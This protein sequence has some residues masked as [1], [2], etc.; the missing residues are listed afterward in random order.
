L[1][2]SAAVAFHHVIHIAASSARRHQLK[3]IA[4]SYTVV[5]GRCSGRLPLDVQRANGIE[6]ATAA[7][8]TCS[9]DCSVMASIERPLQSNVIG[10]FSAS[11]QQSPA[12]QLY[13]G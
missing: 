11:K 1:Q 13:S 7:A 6:D 12:K 5:G 10:I 4:L 9:A 3:G 2:S 8:A